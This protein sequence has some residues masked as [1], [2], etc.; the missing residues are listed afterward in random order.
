MTRLL[1]IF[2]VAWLV[3]TVAF[4]VE[5]SNALPSAHCKAVAK[6]KSHGKYKR[7]KYVYSICRKRSVT[8]WRGATASWY[9]PGLYGNGTA[10]GMRYTPSIRGVAHKTMRC[11]TKLTIRY[12]GRSVRVRVIDRGPYAHGRAF[13]LSAGTRADL[14][15]NGV[16]RVRWH[17]GW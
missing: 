5:E 6:A 16:Q 17:K 11:G 1:I 4:K 14:G 12:R 2:L 3:F 13:D 15:F 9:G 8:Q 7:W 10:C